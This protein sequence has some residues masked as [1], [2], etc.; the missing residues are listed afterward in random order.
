[1]V[2]S[3]EKLV[4]FIN[5]PLGTLMGIEDYISLRKKFDK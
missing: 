4:R 1:M 5:N 3:K 2:Y